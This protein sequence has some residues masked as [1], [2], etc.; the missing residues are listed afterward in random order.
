MPDRDR[1]QE[2]G[3]AAPA[4]RFEPIAASPAYK[5]VADAI[6]RQIV[7]GRVRPGE[8][9]GT[10]ADLVKQFGVNRSTVREG[11]RL[12][13][14]GGLIRR[15]S[16]RRLYAS[17]PRYDRLATRISRAFILHEVTFRELWEATMAIESAVVEL[18]ADRISADQLGELDLN[19]HKSRNALDKPSELALLDI[20]FHTILCKAANN[21]VLQLARE[22]ENKLFFPTTE[23][24]FQKNPQAAQRNVRAHAAI[25]DAL[26][27]RDKAEALLW[28][29][30]HVN[31]W[32][33]GFELIGKS[34]DEPIDRI[35]AEHVLET[36]Q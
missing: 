27:K 10:E 28:M 6:E 9:I 18:A 24:L 26:H 7:S 35:Y 33:K 13:E 2:A 19:L 23:M 3:E 25:I 22:P 4:S 29:K 31:D 16:S 11:I 32:K 36:A 5:L 34:I 14:Q 30:R 21:R 15:D 20:E 17:V 8:A 12:L 1:E